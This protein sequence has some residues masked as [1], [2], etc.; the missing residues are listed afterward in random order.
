VFPVYGF[1][2][3]HPK[4][5]DSRNGFFPVSGSF[6][7]ESDSLAE[8]IKQY[9]KC[10][11]S[12]NIS[13]TKNVA[14]IIKKVLKGIDEFKTEASK[15]K[16]KVMLIIS[17]GQIHDIKEVTNK[18]VKSANYPISIIVLGV[19]G[20]NFNELERLDDIKCSL[21]N[22]RSEKPIRNNIQFINLDKFSSFDTVMHTI[23]KRVS[24]QFSHWYNMQT[25]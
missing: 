11:K 19:G 6:D 24:S 2:A 20:G 16:Y 25:W 4:I 13:G 14:G 21:V 12:V 18:I 8:C 7:I 22:H 15:K 9:Q 10:L 23:F 5:T 3:A 17:D 1:G